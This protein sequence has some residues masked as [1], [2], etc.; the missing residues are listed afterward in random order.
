MDAGSTWARN[1]I[2]GWGNFG[3][4]FGG[5]DVEDVAGVRAKASPPGAWCVVLF[6]WQSVRGKHAGIRTWTLKSPFEKGIQ[7]I[8]WAIR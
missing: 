1:L 5:L 8:A 4:Q 3:K 2:S 7:P 6:G